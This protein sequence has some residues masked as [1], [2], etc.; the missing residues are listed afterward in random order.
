MILE[1]VARPVRALSL[2]A[3]GTLSSLGC[4]SGPEEATDPPAVTPGITAPAPVARDSSHFAVRPP[5]DGVRAAQGTAPVGLAG[6]STHPDTVTETIVFLHPDAPP[7][8][9]TKQAAWEEIARKG[10]SREAASTR[11]PFIE[12]VSDCNDQ[13]PATLYDQPGNGGNEVCFLGQGTASLRGLS[14]APGKPV[15]GNIQSVFTGDSP[16]NLLAL[17]TVCHLTCFGFPPHCG[18]PWVCGQQELVV[19]QFSNTFFSYNFVNGS[20]QNADEV[21]LANN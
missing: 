18:L 8:I 16:M 10:A 15:T 2:V 21:F 11:D 20:A 9:I 17:E 6:D 12:Q 4:S 19:E 14:F 1:L 5:I 3:L 7:T 13:N